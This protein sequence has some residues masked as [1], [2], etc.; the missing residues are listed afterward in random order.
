MKLTREGAAL[1]RVTGAEIVWDNHLCMP[2]RIHDDSFMPQL[3][4]C[5]AAGIDV[6]TLPIG[7]GTDPVE[8][9]LRILAQFRD[10]VARHPDLCRL[11]FSVA[12]IRAARAAGQIGVCFD[13]EGMG[14]VADQPSLVSL[15][16]ELGVR[17]MLITYNRANAAGGGCLEDDKGLTPF[18]RQIIERMNEVGMV[19]CCTHAGYRTAR[20]A[21]D[22]SS[23]PMIFSHSNPRAVHDHPRNIPDDLMRACAQRGGVI[24]INGIGIFLGKNDASVETFIRHVEHALDVVGDDHVG[25]ATDYLMDKAEADEALASR[26]LDFPPELFPRDI[27]MAMIPPWELPQV[28]QALH[29]RGHSPETLAKLFGGNHMR[30]A[31]QV[32]R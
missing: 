31:Q 12:D 11:V 18:G 26:P 28:A 3:E 10:W 6:V 9:H 2:L 15:Y 22:A 30:I 23:L 29:A 21:I 8:Q 5:R 25:I 32:W 27:G 19:L 16:Y 20:E 13:I 7:Y 24:G 14:A 17:W 1:R 4:R